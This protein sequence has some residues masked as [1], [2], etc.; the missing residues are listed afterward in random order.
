MLL[1]PG[2]VA[3]WQWWCIGIYASRGYARAVAFVIFG[4]ERRKEYICIREKKGMGCW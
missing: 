2:F 4:M 1:L 3:V